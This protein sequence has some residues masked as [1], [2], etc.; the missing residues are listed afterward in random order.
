MNTKSSNEQKS[1][2]TDFSDLIIRKF[3]NR[4][5]LLFYLSGLMIIETLV[6]KNNIVEKYNFSISFGSPLIIVLVFSIAVLF[7]TWN[8]DWLR[9][10]AIFWF[11]LNFIVFNNVLDFS[12]EKSI[13]ISLVM[14]I[15]SFLTT[16]FFHKKE[17][18]EKLEKK[19]YRFQG[20]LPNGVR[21]FSN[22]NLD[23][24][25]VDKNYKIVKITG[26]DLSD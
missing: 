1:Q 19:G 17:R 9:V 3:I 22:E 26:L 6:M 10:I 4:K 8:R 20:C 23:I 16:F 24:A 18:K 15:P 13:I 25:E 11:L 12:F 5:N 21:I 7:W 14:A 2:D